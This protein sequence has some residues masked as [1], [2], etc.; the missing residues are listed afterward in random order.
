MT[1]LI[2]RKQTDPFDRTKQ[3]RKLLV[4]RA[5][6]DIVET[7]QEVEKKKIEI[8]QT[9]MPVSQGTQADIDFHCEKD[10]Q[11]IKE[12]DVKLASVKQISERRNQNNQNLEAKNKVLVTARFDYLTKIRLLNEKNSHIYNHAK[13]AVQFYE[14]K[15]KKIG[16]AEMINRFETLTTFFSKTDNWV[17]QMRCLQ[18]WQQM[19]YRL[20]FI[21]Y[22]KPKV[23]ILRIHSDE[24]FSISSEHTPR[25]IRVM[26]SKAV[27]VSVCKTG[28]SMMPLLSSSMLMPSNGDY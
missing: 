3:C 18:M 13:E 4:N 26:P 27:S 15:I 5:I 1:S 25:D 28:P 10:I 22:K 23:D 8:E 19:M 24:K 9:K 20:L 16:S 17:I 2:Q 14:F 11:K 21:L 7:L 12:L 6:K